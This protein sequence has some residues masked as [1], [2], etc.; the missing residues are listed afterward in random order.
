METQ[1]IEEFVATTPLNARLVVGVR[2]DPDGNY[3]TITGGTVLSKY[4]NHDSAV[5]YAKN[6]IAAFENDTDAVYPAVLN[7]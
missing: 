4:D 7:S 5:S 6:V 2:S 3:I 1:I